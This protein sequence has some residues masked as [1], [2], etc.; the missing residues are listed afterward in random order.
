MTVSITSCEEYI[1]AVQDYLIENL[2]DDFDFYVNQDE[3]FDEESIKQAIWDG[4][5]PADYVQR[6]LI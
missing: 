3:L 1:S 2:G 5:E 6:Y 4:V